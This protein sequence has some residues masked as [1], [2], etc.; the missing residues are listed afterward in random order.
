MLCLL[1]PA[2]PALRLLHM[3][4][5]SQRM[6]HLMQRRCRKLLN[7]GPPWSFVISSMLGRREAYCRGPERKDLDSKPR[8]CFLVR[9]G[10]Q[11]GNEA[12][13]GAGR[14]LPPKGASARGR[15]R[16]RGLVWAALEAGTAMS[17]Q[18][19]SGP[20]SLYAPATRGARLAPHPGSSTI[21]SLCCRI[22]AGPRYGR[23][24]V[25]TNGC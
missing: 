23:R 25:S 15:H 17:S 6:H 16:D 14:E 5:K 1:L 18:A 13:R 22:C 4:S 2:S 8:V 24:V 12:S 10:R 9:H 11:Q 19:L 7:P 20:G 21:W 3:R